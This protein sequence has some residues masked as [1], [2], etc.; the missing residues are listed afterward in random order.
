[1][2]AIERNKSASFL[3][4]PIFWLEE[5][6]AKA[7]DNLDVKGSLLKMLI[8]F[9]RNLNCGKKVGLHNTQEYKTIWGQSKQLL[10]DMEINL[11]RNFFGSPS[12]TLLIF[13]ETSKM[14]EIKTL[15]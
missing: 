15:N 13:L 9:T 10:F 3:F 7:Q 12:P 5:A 1:M 6:R 2:A 14:M 4:L 8:T 11:D